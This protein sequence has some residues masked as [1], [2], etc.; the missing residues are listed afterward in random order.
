MEEPGGTD[1]GPQGKEGTVSMNK[2]EM[3]TLI[4]FS[5]SYWK[6]IKEKNQKLTKTWKQTAMGEGREENECVKR[7]AAL[8]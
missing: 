7:Q 8:H 1:V 5:L 3:L 6:K 2:E 4:R